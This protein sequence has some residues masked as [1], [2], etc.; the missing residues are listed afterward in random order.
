MISR[1]FIGYLHLTFQSYIFQLCCHEITLRFKRK[2]WNTENNVD[3][4]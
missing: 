1:S 3:V 2:M 4:C